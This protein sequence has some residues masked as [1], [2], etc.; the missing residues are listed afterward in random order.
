MGSLMEMSAPL[1]LAPVRPHN[2][3]LHG[4]TIPKRDL[5]VCGKC[6]ATL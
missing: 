5:I 6:G 4:V 2:C 3:A 1:K